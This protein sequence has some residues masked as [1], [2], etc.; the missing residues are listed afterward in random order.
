MLVVERVLRMPADRIV[1]RRL[2]VGLLV[3]DFMNVRESRYQSFSMQI[4]TFPTC[5]V[6]SPYTSQI[7][8]PP[9]SPP[10]MNIL[11]FVGPQNV[12]FPKT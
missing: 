5:E 12:T 4:I 9:E 8:L 6:L 7:K 2:T 11:N 1:Q 10:G 3:K